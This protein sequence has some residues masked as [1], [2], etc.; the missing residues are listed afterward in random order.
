M[1]TD[2]RSRIVLA[3]KSTAGAMFSK[4]ATAAGRVESKLA[5]IAKVGALAGATLVAAFGANAIRQS[6]QFGAAIGDLAAITGATGKDLEF[7]SDK[8]KEFG[9]TTTLS[10]SAAAE[11]FKL[12]ASAKPDLLENGAALAEVTRQTILL[13]EASGVGLASA[14]ATVGEALNQFGA[15]ANQAARFVNVLAAGSKRGSSEVAQTAEALRNAGVAAAAAG[16]SFEE[17][18]ALIQTMAASGIKGADAG[19]KLRS[20]MTKLEVQANNDFNPAVVGMSKALD[21][22]A[23]AHLD[24]GELV[25][26]FGEKQIITGRILI[27]NRA[28][29][30][31]LTISLTGTNVA[32]E[33]AAARNDNLAGDLKKLKSAFEGLSIEIGEKFDPSL[34]GLTQRGTDLLNYFTQQTEATEKAVEEFETLD[35]VINGLVSAYTALTT[36]DDLFTSTDAAIFDTIKA[37]FTD[38]IDAAVDVAKTSFGGIRD[39]LVEGF[40]EAFE[41]ATDGVASQLKEVLES[42]EVLSTA[43]EAA[44]KL[45]EAMAEATRA[46]AERAAEVAAAIELEKFQATIERIRDQ[47]L[48]EEI[49]LGEKLARDLALIEDAR[50]RDLLSLDEFLDIKF[51]M[52]QA[53]SDRLK[54]MHAKND[55]DAQKFAKLTA[56]GKTKFVLGEMAAITAGVASESKVMFRI[57]QAAAL[58]NAIINIHEGI[59]KAWALGPILGPPMAALVAAAGAVQ[60]A[61]IASASPGGGTTPSASGTTASVGGHPVPILPPPTL[62]QLGDGEGGGV[63]T[64]DINISGLPEAGVIPA[65]TV[66]ELMRS[67][68]EELGD[69]ANLNV[70]GGSSGGT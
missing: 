52:E 11:A 5:R 22:M 37:F 55:T 20:V 47:H 64:I 66:R 59:S 70:A 45:A 10:A 65:E 16:V 31:E 54:K 51:N 17:T 68:N 28:L 49:L 34:R 24:T 61:G 6:T 60:I 1:P 25:D 35:A 23:A 57:N 63:R 8:A 40:E 29:F 7:L 2:F 3:G 48:S 14:A 44:A 46:S 56:R 13:A 69:G 67:I 36:I 50:M 9:R 19:T 18:N 38:G 62:D 4:T 15:D 41:I 33:Q 39:S 21:N 30:D 53:A 26:I 12:V 43:S 27:N 58:G 32:L 42:P